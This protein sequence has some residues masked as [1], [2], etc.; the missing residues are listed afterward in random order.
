MS[1][2]RDLTQLISEDVI[3]YIQQLKKFITT[4]TIWKRWDMIIVMLYLKNA[5]RG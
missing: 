1:N 3:V 2:D 5:L 4:K